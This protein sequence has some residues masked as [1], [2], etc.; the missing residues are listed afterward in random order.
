MHPFNT[1]TDITAFCQ[2]NNIVVEAYAPLVRALRMKHPTIVSLS[3]KYSCTPGQLLVRWSLQ[4]GYVPLPKSVRQARI[5]ENSQIGG[6][7]IDDDDIKVMDGLDECLVT[8]ECY[9]ES[10]LLR[11]AT[12]GRKGGGGGSSAFALTDACSLYRLGSDRLRVDVEGEA[13]G[14]RVAWGFA[15]VQVVEGQQDGQDRTGQKCPGQKQ[16]WVQAR[17]TQAVRRWQGCARR[18]TGWASAD[19]SKVTASPPHAWPSSTHLVVV[20]RAC[21]SATQA[22]AGSLTHRRPLATPAQ[23][24]NVKRSA[25][26]D[27]G[28]T[29]TLVNYTSVRSL[30]APQ[31]AQGHVQTPPRCA[32]R[33]AHWPRLLSVQNQTPW[34]A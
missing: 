29:V 7:E 12:Q 2:Q 16:T 24:R 30:A 17:C 34:F 15:C 32:A 27:T 33:A 18:A 21:A 5:M 11:H 8:G 28:G 19:R 4:H 1:R 20:L 26:P 3:K 13:E 14:G 25:R 31:P 10:C 6:F 22:R 23:P 9:L